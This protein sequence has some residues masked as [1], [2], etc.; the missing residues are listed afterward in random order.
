MNYG[1]EKLYPLLLET[2]KFILKE[3]EWFFII[4]VFEI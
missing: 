4:F 3:S 2:S 1:A